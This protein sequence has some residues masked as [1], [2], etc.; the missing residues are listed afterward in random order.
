MRFLWGFLVVAAGYLIVWKRDWL[1]RNFGRIDWAE[2]HLG[3]QGG[4]RIFYQLLGIGIIFIGLSIMT[5]IWE[6]MM[7]SFANL[8]VH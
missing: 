7:N 1:L 6:D 4:S 5:G 3:L 2:E 8:F